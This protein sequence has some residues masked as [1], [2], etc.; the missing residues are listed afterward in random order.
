[1]MKTPLREIKKKKTH[2]RKKKECIYIFKHLTAN[3]GAIKGL[4]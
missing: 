2:F 1:M 3:W 4:K